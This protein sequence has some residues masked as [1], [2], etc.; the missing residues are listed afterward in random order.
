MRQ[1]ADILSLED[2]VGQLKGPVLVTGAAGFVGARLFASLNQHRDDI[3]ALIHNE[4]GWRLANVSDD[5]IIRCDLTDFNASSQVVRGFAP[6]TVFHCVAYGAY[7]FENDAS[8]IYETNVAS[9]VNLIR[10]LS[11]GP[12]SAFVHAGTSSEY[13][14][15]CSGPT[16]DADCRPNSPYAASKAAA[17]QYLRLAGEHDGF[18]CANL[19]LYSVYGPLEDTSRLVPTLVNE[20]LQGRLPPL[21]DNHITRDFVHV[22]DVC[23]AF[24][25]A[26]ICIDSIHHGDSFNIGTGQSTSIGAIA[27]IARQLFNVKE[28]P[29]F[30]SMENRTWDL[31]D[32]YSNPTRAN[33]VFGWRAEIELDDGLRSVADWIAEMPEDAFR[34]STK[35]DSELS[36]EPHGRSI[37]AVVA[38]Y[39]DADAIPLMHQ[40]LTGVF[41]RLGVDY[42]IVFVNDGSPDDSEQVI[43]DISRRDPRVVGVTHSRN[44]G[45]QMAFRSGMEI[46]SKE[47]VVLLDGDLQDPPELI[48][49]FHRIWLDGHDVVYGVRTKREMSWFRSLGHKVFYRLFRKFSYIEVPV[50][51]GD[52]SLM[53]RRVVEWLLESP[54]RDLFIRGL[55][56][57]VGFRQTGVEYVRPKRVFGVSTNDLSRNIGWAKRGIFSYSDAPLTMLTALGSVAFVFSTTAALVIAMLRLL[58]PDLAPRGATTILITILLFGSFNLLA[59]GLVGEY[60]A[61][62]MTEVKRRPRLIRASVIRD[63]KKEELD[64]AD[65]RH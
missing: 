29:R 63:G 32:W 46:A 38:C 16:E 11:G 22:D 14:T 24:V 18:P 12:L 48:E 53:D 2:L 34:I 35:K 6:R 3:G 10:L 57:Y 39:R 17:S 55:R 1:T 9:L 51:A 36:V 65:Q 19:R 15:N 41:S 30:G 50:D 49:D 54:E 59:I 21:V 45:S 5:R 56:A 8:L 27:G 28:Q 44:F 7:P 31:S 58:V 13:G 37:S 64:L 42:E 52:F 60:V 62:I 23:R 20:A 61:R 47:A 33:E 40:R 4:K 26:A 25:Q 43:L